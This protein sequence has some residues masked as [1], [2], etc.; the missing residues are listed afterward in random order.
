M[1]VLL[2]YAA[3]SAAVDETI[4]YPNHT[5]QAQTNLVLA[6]EPNYWPNCFVL[7]SLVLN[8]APITS[9]ALDGHKL[10]IQLPAV[11]APE[12]VATLQIQFKLNLPQIEPTNPNLT[13]P[14]IFGFTTDQ[15]NLVNWY[16][17][18]VPFMNGQWVL[19]DAWYYGDHLFFD[20]ADFDVNLKFADPATAPIVAASGAPTPA[21]TGSAN[22]GTRYTLI[23][24]RN[25]AFSISPEFKVS[26][27][28]VGNVTVSSYYFPLFESPGQAALRATAEAVQVFSQRYGP[29]P[30]KTL[31]VVM[32]DFQD[33]LE[34]S[35][36]FFHSMSFYNTYDGTD[37]NY[38][39]F[40]AAHET[41]HQWW[42]EQVGNDRAMQPWLAEALAVYSEHIFY[43]A[44]D[45]NLVPWWWAYRVDYY[46][47]TGWVDTSIYAAGGYRPF[48]DAVYLR[49]A[50]FLD[51]L[52]KRIGDQ[53]F[54]AFLQDYLKQENGKIA[55]AAD[56]FRILRQH[57]TAD[58]SDIVRQ[59]FQNVY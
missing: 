34:F 5:G 28:Q 35:A 59:Y 52:R 30:H 22:E 6:V 48:L 39:T 45:P 51:D 31:S 50:H 4:V 21:S 27:Q 53:D 2:D 9:F 37:K 41:A 55:T 38:L 54:F 29:Y 43:E 8:G 3:K 7:N 10:T 16:P 47:P 40:I 15:I 58:F 26:T 11:L 1:N 25:F 36:F 17:F 13:R 56:F 12:S 32:G 49:G 18:I 23:A 33:S 44:T 57:T 20:S 19:H 24:G 14:R 42:Y 46:K